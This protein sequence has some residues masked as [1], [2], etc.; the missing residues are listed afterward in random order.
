MKKRNYPTREEFENIKHNNPFNIIAGVTLPLALVMALSSCSQATAGVA[1]IPY[2]ISE[3]EALDIIKSEAKNYNLNLDSD[4]IE[5]K[6]LPLQYIN[7]KKVKVKENFTF[8]T[9]LYNEQFNVGFEYIS[10]VDSDF[11]D[12]IE[13]GKYRSII[14]NIKL[15]L[16]KNKKYKYI[17]VI[18]ERYSADILREQV[19]E[20]L[21][22]LVSN[23][24]I[25]K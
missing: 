19:K 23:G 5:V 2:V 9:D 22:W 12:L 15:D 3:Q 21:E 11:D 17:K 18:D 25:V 13:K 16:N 24:I 4:N 10:K 8:S 1:P 7:N 14:K 6:N 20:H